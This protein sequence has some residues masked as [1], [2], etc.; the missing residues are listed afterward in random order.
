MVIFTAISCLDL[1]RY[2]LFKK[3]TWTAYAFVAYCFCFLNKV[4]V[5]FVDLCFQKI[6]NIDEDEEADG[7]DEIVASD[8]EQMQ[9]LLE[10]KVKKTKQKKPQELTTPFVL[11][12]LDTNAK[13]ESTAAARWALK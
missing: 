10:F 11:C 9:N 4:N 2:A 5:L 1:K 13:P 7:E 12:R 6:E 8:L 3:S